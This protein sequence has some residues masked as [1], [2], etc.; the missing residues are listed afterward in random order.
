MIPVRHV[1]LTHYLDE[2]TKLWRGE[3]I[4]PVQ[5]I[6]SKQSL[7]FDYR[8]LKEREACLL[9]LL[10]DSARAQL[11]TGNQL[12]KSDLK[13]INRLKKKKINREKK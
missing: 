7:L 11:T 3:V 12:A 13:K 4:S 2:E 5:F 8:L 10:Q 1:S 9:P 6:S